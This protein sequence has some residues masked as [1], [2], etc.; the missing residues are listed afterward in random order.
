M[1][2]KYPIKGEIDLMIY[3]DKHK[4]TTRLIN[5]Y[6]RT[7]AKEQDVKRIIRMSNNSIKE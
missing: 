7:I 5:I 4:N 3:Y 6:Q 2:P 1:A